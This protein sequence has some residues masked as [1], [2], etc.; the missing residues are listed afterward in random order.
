MKFK[1]FLKRFLCLML[2]T[3]SFLLVACDSLG[4]GLDE[5]ASDSDMI[6]NSIIVLSGEPS[7]RIVYSAD[8]KSLAQK[9]SKKLISLDESYVKGS[10]KYEIVL[11]TEVEE[12]GTP[13][14]LIGD[15]NRKATK[16]AK[17]T[18]GLVTKTFVV[19]V[20]DKSI[21][22]YAKRKEVL[23]YA[24][25]YVLDNFIAQNNGSVVY[26]L[27]NGEIFNFYGQLETE[28]PKKADKAPILE[29]RAPVKTDIN[30]DDLL[31]GLVSAAGS[32]VYSIAVSA[33]SGTKVAKDTNPHNT[34]SVSK[35]FCVTAIGMLYDEGK[36]KMTDTIGEIFKSEIKAYGI[37][38]NKWKTVT[39]DDVLRHRAGYTQGA[40]LDIDKYPELKDNHDDFLKLVL[41]YKI[42]TTR[43][44]NG[45]IGYKYTDAAYYLI[46]RVVSKISGQKLD[47]YL[48]SRLFTPADMKKYSTTYCP[49]GYPIGATQ[50]FMRS[51]D[52]VKLGRIYL[53]GGKYNGKQIISQDWIN[54][55]IKN[56]YELTPDCNGYAKGGMNGQMLYVNFEHNVAVAWLSETQ[57]ATDDLYDQLT[58]HLPKNK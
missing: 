10:G 19:R 32:K 57:G 8:Y 30:A 48:K 40:L 23:T 33:T 15:T 38:E 34:Y 28:T 49:Q 6:D 3:A 5:S 37:D 25:E 46:S 58:T 39:I 44:K 51:E 35:V 21:V 12:D 50:F 27:A 41:S 2:V 29:V 13:E 17:K 54:Q 14:I 55:V 47:E 24:V 11:D 42:D 16:E 1:T 18:S 56:G 52:V 9:V 22:I 36:I 43:D 26:Y 31:A 45:D 7:Y 4:E 53:D 20:I